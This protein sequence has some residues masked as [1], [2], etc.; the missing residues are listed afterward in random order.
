MAIVGMVTKSGRYLHPIGIGTWTF[1]MY[2][3]FS[4]GSAAEVAAIQYGIGLGQNHIDTAE[5]YA[6][7]GA[8]QVVGRAIESLPRDDLFIASKLWKSHVAKGAVRPAVE[9]MLRRLGT[10]YVDLL[11]I[12]APWFD[13]PWQEAVPQI[14]EL[15]DEGMVRYFGV[16]NFNAAHLREVL[17]LTTQPIAANQ[18]HYNCDHQSEVTPEL[19]LLC[20]E[21][22]IQIVAYSPLAQ[23]GDVQNQAVLDLAR[24]YGVSPSQVALAWL[25]ARGTLPIPKALQKQHIADNVAAADLRLTP[26]DVARI[27]HQ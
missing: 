22:N 9:A 23:N 13:A 5:M 1:G 15:I 11:Y 27:T 17:A 19:E 10:D 26:D 7:G 8:E 24:A 12:H 2:A 20:H 21:N 6:S 4:P 25:V 14:C 18:M 16:S 3:P